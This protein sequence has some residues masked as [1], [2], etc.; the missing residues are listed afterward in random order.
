ML[1]V[2]SVF[3][4]RVVKG[5]KSTAEM[6]AHIRQRYENCL[7]AGLQTARVDV[8]REAKRAEMA[9]VTT[10]TAEATDDMDY[11]SPST[12][13][14][15]QSAGPA[16]PPLS[17]IDM[18]TLLRECVSFIAMQGETTGDVTVDNGAN[19]KVRIDVKR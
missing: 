10:V 2:F 19:G 12:G 6:K 9:T 11:R 3:F 13:D 4:T 18:G 8:R 15:S 1:A 17:H 16:D 14:K 5:Q 7:K